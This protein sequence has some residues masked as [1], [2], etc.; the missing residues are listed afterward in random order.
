MSESTHV[1][2]SAYVS[3]DG[4]YRYSLERLWGTGG[5]FVLIVCLNPSVADATQSDPTLRRMVSFAEACGYDGLRVANLFALRSTDH[6]ALAAHSDP[7]GSEN[8]DWI[9]RVQSEASCV[10]AAWGNGGSLLGRSHA[11]RAMLRS[12]AMCLGQTQQRELRHPLYVAK[13]T[14]LSTLDI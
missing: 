12:D 5:R 9:S 11:V 6:R 3:P 7:I 1:R 10:V 8:D 4:V 14:S 2:S 13:L